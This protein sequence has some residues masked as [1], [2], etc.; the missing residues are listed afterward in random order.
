MYP[1][2]IYFLRHT[3]CTALLRAGLDL[4]TVQRLM[5]HANIATTEYCLHAIETGVHP[6]DRLPY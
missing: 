4:R 6:T 1:L 3:Y 5:G 2:T